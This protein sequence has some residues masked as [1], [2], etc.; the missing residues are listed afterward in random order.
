MIELL[1]EPFTLPSGHEVFVGASIGISLFPDDAATV[2]ELIQHADVAMYQAKKSGRNTYRF[3]TPAL[4]R[5][6]NERLDLEARLRRG[7]ARGRIRAAF[8]AQID[9][10]AAPCS[11]AKRWCVGRIPNAG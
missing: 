1:A 9:L 3:Y 5:A 4:T 7:A 2:T 11:A 6:A 10:A 8:P